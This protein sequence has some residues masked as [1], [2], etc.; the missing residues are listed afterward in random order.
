[1]PTPVADN[2]IGFTLSV[3]DPATIIA[4]AT[5][6]LAAAAA[7]SIAITALPAAAGTIPTG[8]TLLFNG[9][10]V[11]VT[12]SP[13]AP[14]A[15]T[16]AVAAL[17]A[18]IPSGATSSFSLFVLVSFVER[19]GRRGTRN[20]NTRPVFGQQE[21]IETQGRHRNTVTASGIVSVNDPG[22]VILRARAGDGASANIKALKDGTN[23]YTMV[24]GVTDDSSD[25]SADVDLGTFSYTLTAKG[26]APILVGAAG[27]LF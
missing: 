22:Q 15:V 4:I 2:F 16:I 1:M 5:T 27:A 23:G 25:E 13:T 20:S 7:V 18:P 14:G 26:S 12:T 6:A 9:N 24:V 10:L 19:Y 11:A 21:E 17:A 3:E 8:T